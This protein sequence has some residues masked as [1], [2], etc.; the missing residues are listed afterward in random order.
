MKTFVITF[1]TNL[2]NAGKFL[3][4]KS[5]NLITSA[6]FLLSFKVTYSWVLGVRL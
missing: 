6:N 5:F 1:R 3:H 2:N 4:L